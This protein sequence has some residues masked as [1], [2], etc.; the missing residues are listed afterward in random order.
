MSDGAAGAP[1]VLVAV[2]TYNS[3]QHVERLLSALPS[4]LGDFQ[5]AC[6]V[7]VDNGSTDRTVELVRRHAPRAV[8]LESGANIG[9]G[10]A[11]NRALAHS[12]PGRAVLVLNPDLAP[13]PG[14]LAALVERLKSPGVGIAVPRIVDTAGRLKFS[15]RWEPTLLRAIGEALLGGHRAARH[16][17]LGDMIRDPDTYVDGATADW[18]TGAVMAISR[19]V[20]DA[21]GG[22]DESFFLYS[23]ETDYALRARD[24]GFALSFVADAE[25]MHPGGEMSRSP[26]L[27]SMLAVNRVRLYRRRHGFVAGGAYWLVVLLNESARAVLGRPTHR[28]AVRALFRGPSYPSDAVV[29]PAR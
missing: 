12:R 8:V 16:P 3:E 18:A 10:A 5:D 4:A 1:D 25:V 19:P 13:A 9:Y 6:V 24:A 22:W 11:I 28:A 29:G 20:L 2:V 26:M 27:W 14:A 17:A 21:I 23:E 15:L 7:V